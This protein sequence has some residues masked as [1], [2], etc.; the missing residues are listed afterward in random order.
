VAAVIAVVGVALLVSSHGFHHPTLGDALMLC[1]AATRACMVT[2][3]GH[4]TDGQHF[5]TLFLTLV[6]CG[7]CAVVLTAVGGRGDLHAL[8]LLQGGD[9]FAL[10][11]LGI[12]CSVIGL[13]IQMW[14]VRETSAT[15]ASLLLGTEPLWAV[16]VAA[17][18]GHETTTWIGILGGALIIGST[19]VAQGIEIRHR[20]T[21]TLAEHVV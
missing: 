9:W 12:G 1:A 18:V 6:Q 19:Y 4:L 17:V 20:L 3:S 14:A 16:I 21:P 10:A 15:R 13:L 8:S 11:Y 2:S 7:S 5:D